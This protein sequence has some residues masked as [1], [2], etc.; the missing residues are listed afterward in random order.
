MRYT[1]AF[2]MGLFLTAFMLALTGC[3]DPKTYYPTDQEKNEIEFAGH[4]TKVNP[5]DAC[6]GSC[7]DTAIYT[8]IG[9]AY[10]DGAI[11]KMELCENQDM[12][13]VGMHVAMKIVGTPGKLCYR[14][15]HTVLLDPFTEPPGK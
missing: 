13:R 5:Y 12:L 1:G 9:V 4:I 3:D 8:E 14:V 2:L 15:V 11:N 6:A 10:D 7:S